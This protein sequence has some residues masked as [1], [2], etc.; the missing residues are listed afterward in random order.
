[1]G[2]EIVNDVISYV[3]GLLIVVDCVCMIIECFSEC[4][5]CCVV[6]F[7]FLKDGI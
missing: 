7:V 3:G 6:E 2:D 1:M 4:N 5:D